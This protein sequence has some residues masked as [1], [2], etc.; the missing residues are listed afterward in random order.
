[1]FCRSLILNDKGEVLG[2]KQKP[3]ESIF[4]GLSAVNKCI[5]LTTEDRA[6]IIGYN[7]IEKSENVVFDP[8]IAP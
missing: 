2:T 6:R 3:R 8:N 4:A 1:M 7:F 5:Y